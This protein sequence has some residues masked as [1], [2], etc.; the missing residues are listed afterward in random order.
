MDR[1]APD[2]ADPEVEETRPVLMLITD[3][4][5]GDPSLQMMLEHAGYQVVAVEPGVDPIVAARRNRPR[6]L[7]LSVVTPT[8]AALD[9]CRI[10]KADPIGEDV[11]ALVVSNR[12]DEDII[13]AAGAAGAHELMSKPC[14]HHVRLDT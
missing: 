13:Q 2:F 3:A 14:A 12:L 10:L 8:G 6:G 9:A 11:P 4:T 5:E 7:I 1:G